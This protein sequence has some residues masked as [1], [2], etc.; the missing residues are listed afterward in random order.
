LIWR[1]GR[2]PMGRSRPKQLGMSPWPRFTQRDPF[3]G[4]LESPLSRHPYIYTPDSPLNFSD[5]SGLDWFFADMGKVI[6]RDIAAMYQTDPVKAGHTI[7]PFQGIP[8]TGGKLLPDIVDVT[9][10]QIGEIKPLSPYGIATGMVQ[11]PAYLAIANGITFTYKD[12]TWTLPPWL[13][14][15]WTPSTW[16]PGVR[17]I[18]PGLHEL[19][20]SNWIAFTLVNV[21][22]LIFYKAFPLPPQPIL[23]LVTVAALGYRLARLIDSY[24]QSLPQLNFDIPDTAT[25]IERMLY[26]ALAVTTAG[27]AV[28]TGAALAANWEALGL[29][30][31][32]MID[33]LMPTS[34]L[35]DVAI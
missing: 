19:R 26:G 12:T 32:S 30:I 20:F 13:G 21:D 17:P 25:V 15:G 1:A 35:A 29:A 8:G 31:V 33:L 18:F 6:E 3:T 11:L 28:S 9:L 7:R 24:L 16:Q 14:G 10:K 5:P 2:R 23:G 22:G 34:R 27:L 4:F